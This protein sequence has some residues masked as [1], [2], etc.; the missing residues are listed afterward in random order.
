VNGERLAGERVPLTIPLGGHVE[1][2][3]RFTPAAAGPVELS[4]VSEKAG[5]ETFQDRRRFV[6][7]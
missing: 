5:R 2:R 4:L 1:Q 6:A 3:I 7:R